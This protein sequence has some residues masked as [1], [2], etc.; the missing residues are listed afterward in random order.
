MPILVKQKLSRNPHPVTA[1]GAAFESWG[2]LAE[3]R[4]DMALRHQ[5]FGY[6]WGC[7]DRIAI[8]RRA[9]SAY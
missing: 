1:L 5:S 3:A 8:D 9:A 7:I 6:C 2:R 4:S